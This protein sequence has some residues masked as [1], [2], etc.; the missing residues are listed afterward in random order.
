MEGIGLA[1]VAPCSLRAPG[2]RSHCRCLRFGDGQT[3]DLDQPHDDERGARRGCGRTIVRHADTTGCALNAAKSD[4]GG[5]IGAELIRASGGPIPTRAPSDRLSQASTTHV[6]IRRA[7]HLS[8]RDSS[9]RMS[10]SSSRSSDSRVSIERFVIG[11]CW[12][13]LSALL[14]ALASRRLIQQLPVWS[15][16]LSP[17]AQAPSQ[18]VTEPEL[19]R[20]QESTIV[21]P[22]GWAAE[23]AAP[24]ATLSLSHALA[25]HP[26]I[27]FVPTADQ[28]LGSHKAAPRG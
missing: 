26:P 16:N 12:S 25:T 23:R 5:G 18:L 6:R 10:Y 22:S 28:T 13:E 21:R 9:R 11:C 27:Y 3:Q 1:T 14:S 19:T 15:V 7:H 24:P 4:S 2:S 20:A 17:V 8:G